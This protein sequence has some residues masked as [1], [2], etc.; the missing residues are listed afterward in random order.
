MP[1]KRTPLRRE[2]RGRISA[3]QE[4]ALWL[5]HPP[6]A[7]EDEQEARDLWERHCDRLMEMFATHG[8]RPLAWWRYDSP[9][10]YPGQ[11]LERSALY[12][13]G[14]LG[15]QEREQLVAEWREEFERAQVPGFSFCVGML[16]G[17]GARWLSGQAAREA[18]YAWADIPASLIEQ[19]CTERKAVAVAG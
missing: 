11:D 9:I 13:A 18:L 1:T 15:E 6:D 19:W 3:D 10:P 5:G 7:F 2:R 17:G 16:I 12:E 8:R 4:M 14:L